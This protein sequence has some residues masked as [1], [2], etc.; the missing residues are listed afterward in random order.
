MCVC[1]HVCVCLLLLFFFPFSCVGGGGAWICEYIRVYVCVCV[2]KPKIKELSLM[3][4]ILYSMGQGLLNPELTDV[5]L[6]R[7][8]IQA[9]H[10]GHL[11]FLWI[12]EDSQFWFSS[13]AGR[14]LAS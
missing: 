6:L 5:H 14:I 7:L 1:P 3:A 13:L 9:S 4:F 12:S 11:A 10:H 2:C 8:E